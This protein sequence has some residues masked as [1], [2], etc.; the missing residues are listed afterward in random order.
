[1]TK[2]GF[3]LVEVM[4]SITI[5]SL[6]MAFLYESLNHSKKFNESFEKHVDKYM[7]TFDLQKI[8]NEDIMETKDS[9]SLSTDKDKNTILQITNTNNTYHNPFNKYVTYLLSKENNILRIE[10]KIKYNTKEFKS[11]FFDDENTYIDI[12][13][14]DIK[15][16]LVLKNTKNENGY[17][18]Y[19][20]DTNSKDYL[21]SSKKLIP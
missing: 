5:F 6:V 12:V 19:I 9:I 20:K 21:F 1:M 14:K 3:T 2:K 18:F 4:V 15:K 11:E 7:E 10:S 13:A 8:I 17:T 16:F